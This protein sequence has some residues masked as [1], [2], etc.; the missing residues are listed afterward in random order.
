VEG[1]WLDN[2]LKQGKLDRTEYLKLAARV[3]IG[4]QRRLAD[5]R[6][7]ERFERETATAQAVDQEQAL[8]Q[9][10]LRPAKAFDMTDAFINAFGPG[11]RFH[12]R[13]VLAIIGGTNLGKSMLAADVLR[14]VGERLGLS[15]FVEVTVENNPHL[16][17]SD[18]DR[19]IHAGV[20]LDGVGDAL[21]LKQNREALQGRAKQCKGAQSATMMYSYNYSLCRRAVVATFDLSAAHLDAF[22]SDHWL[23]CQDNVRVL[24]LEEKAFEEEPVAA[25]TPPLPLL[26]GGV[27]DPS[28]PHRQA[29][30]RRLLHS[31]Q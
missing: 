7:V 20:L 13:P 11:T 18:F 14:K 21:I 5:V 19:N 6:A 15:S 24:R 26:D 3:C 30:K 23:G 2:L 29:W 31:P 25:A 16:D 4:F 1:W 10:T 8:L 28:P 22:E 12:R 17:F 27:V 9:P